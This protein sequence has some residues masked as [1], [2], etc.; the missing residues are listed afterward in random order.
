VALDRVTNPHNVGAI[1]RTLGW[2][3]GSALLVNDPSPTVNP[4]AMRVSQGGGELL[5]VI[6]TSDLAKAF[7]QLRRHGITTF[8]ADQRSTSPV[9]Q[10]A[11]TGVCFAMGN[12]GEGLSNRVRDACDAAVSIPGVGAIESL[13][14]S[15]AAGILL[16][17]NH[18][19]PAPEPT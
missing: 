3:G 2:F 13:N 8:A 5:P 9:T 15:V 16:A 11:L 19:G 17:F 14:V 12:E 7:G 6:R 4:A 1:L 10:A 18:L